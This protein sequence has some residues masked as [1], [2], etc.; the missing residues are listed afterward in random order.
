MKLRDLIL[1]HGI[2]RDALAYI[3]Q[4]APPVVTLLAY[5]TLHI[6]L[7]Y[8]FFWPLQVFSWPQFFNTL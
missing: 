2:T 7:Q 5:V 4:H 3:L 8:S 6:F 1:E